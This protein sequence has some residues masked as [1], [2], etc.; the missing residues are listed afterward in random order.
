MQA[1]SF[2]HP[3]TPSKK[4]SQTTRHTSS[5]LS[6]ANPSIP[7]VHSESQSTTAY[8]SYCHPWATSCNGTITHSVKQ[9]FDPLSKTSSSKP[10]QSMP[11]LISKLFA[12]RHSHGIP[13]SKPYKT[14]SFPIR[15]P[16]IRWHRP[17]SDYIIRSSTATPSDS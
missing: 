5:T 13:D 14:A 1:S 12:C 6:D 2:I 4:I 17:S 15:Y 7:T 8:L 11:A 3:C 16:P 10:T 9:F